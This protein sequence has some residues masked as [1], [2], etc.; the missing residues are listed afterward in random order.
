MNNLKT[1]NQIFTLEKDITEVIKDFTSTFN[2]AK[3]QKRYKTVLEE[4]FEFLDLKQLDE[5]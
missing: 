4:F 1:Q 3:T 2:S 5:L